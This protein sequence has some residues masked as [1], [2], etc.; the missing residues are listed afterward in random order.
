MKESILKR[1]NKMDDG[2]VKKAASLFMKGVKPFI[3]GSVSRVAGPLG[4][5]LGSQKLN[6]G[7]SVMYKPLDIE[8]P[9]GRKY[10][11]DEIL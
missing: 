5:L 8:M 10:R 7:N 3:K 4:L 11:Y 1:L 6:A 2:G 9:S